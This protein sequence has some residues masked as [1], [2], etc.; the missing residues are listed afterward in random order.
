MS[1]Y[2]AV[3]SAAS[4]ARVSGWPPEL[5]DARVIAVRLGDLRSPLRRPAREGDRTALTA[6]GAG[7]IRAGDVV[8]FCK[9][10]AVAP[11]VVRRDGRVQAGGHPADHARF[12]LAEQRLDEMT[13]QRDAI[14]Q[15]AGQVTPGGKVTGTARRSMTMAATLRAVLLMTLMPHADYREILAVLFGDLAAVPWHAPFAVPAAAVFCA[16]RQAAGP[17]PVARC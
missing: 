7:T 2:P 3:P 5:G 4:P 11:A 6:A 1:L 17:D 9:P 10:A 12:G 8:V 15:V 16:W 13:G 14:G